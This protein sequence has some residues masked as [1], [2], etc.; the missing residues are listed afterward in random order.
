MWVECGKEIKEVWNI[1]VYTFIMSTTWHILYLFSHSTLLHNKTQ[2]E[3]SDYSSNFFYSELQYFSLPLHS[4]IFSHFIL[5]HSFS[6]F[7]LHYV[8]IYGQACLLLC[9]HLLQSAHFLAVKQ[10]YPILTLLFLQ[11]LY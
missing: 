2:R 3:W 9:Q 5:F 10:Q 6:L 7:N 1:K 4:T 11:L 8:L